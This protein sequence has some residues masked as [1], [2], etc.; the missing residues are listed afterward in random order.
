ML[1]ASERDRSRQAILDLAGG[2]ELLAGVPANLFDG[3]LCLRL[4]YNAVHSAMRG[5]AEM[6]VGRWHGRFVHVP[7]QLAIRSRASVVARDTLVLPGTGC[8]Q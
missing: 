8:S 1:I 6:V 4:A 5:R 3:V 7:M 2:E